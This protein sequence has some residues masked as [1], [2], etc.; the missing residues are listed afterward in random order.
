MLSPLTHLYIANH[1]STSV[2]SVPRKVPGSLGCTTTTDED[3]DI[4]GDGDVGGGIDVDPACSPSV[5]VGIVMRRPLRSSRFQRRGTQHLPLI[6]YGD[7]GSMDRMYLQYIYKLMWSR[8][9]TNNNTQHPA[10]RDLL[11]FSSFIL[12]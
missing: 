1:S 7:V 3:S 10:S 8:W 9:L 5:M 6:C 12:S 2:P 11:L 4:V